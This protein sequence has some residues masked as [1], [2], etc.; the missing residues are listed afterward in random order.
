[1]KKL[2]KRRSCF[3]PTVLTQADETEIDMILKRGAQAWWK[4]A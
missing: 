4:L 2:S 1:M 3:H